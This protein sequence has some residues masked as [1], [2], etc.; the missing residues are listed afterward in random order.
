MF[1]N[2]KQTITSEVLEDCWKTLDFHAIVYWY[3]NIQ[4]ISQIIVTVTNC[5]HVIC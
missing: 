3:V 2:Q 5:D 4:P 1:L